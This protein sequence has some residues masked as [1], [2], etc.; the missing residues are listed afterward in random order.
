MV[1]NISADHDIFHR[2][3]ENLKR[4]SINAVHLTPGASSLHG[5]QNGNL[6]RNS[7]NGSTHTIPDK[8]HDSL[9]SMRKKDLEHHLTGLNENYR[10]PCC[11]MVQTIDDHVIK[12][13][14]SQSSLLSSVNNLVK[15]TN[16]KEMLNER[17]K[18]W[19]LAANIVDQTFF[20]LFLVM[21]FSSTVIIFTQA[22]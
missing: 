21:L 6:R 15:Q 9:L 20:V 5:F 13:I 11:H 3:V 7:R 16:A 2:K 1:F 14:D 10:C 19:M 17:K 4:D 12:L 8:H 22:Y 18:E